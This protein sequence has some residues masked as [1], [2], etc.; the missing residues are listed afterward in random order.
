MKNFGRN[1]FTVGVT[2]GS[3]KWRRYLELRL[4]HS[5]TGLTKMQR[6]SKTRRCE[7]VISVCWSLMTL[8]I[9][10]VFRRPL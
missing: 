3:Y 9:T 8:K 5:H 10:R 7:R 6:G 1:M 4:P 2:T